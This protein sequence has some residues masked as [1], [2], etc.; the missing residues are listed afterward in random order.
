MCL[1]YIWWQEGRGQGGIHHRHLQEL[2]MNMLKLGDQKGITS[3]VF[4]FQPPVGSGV[5]WHVCWGWGGSWGRGVINTVGVGMYCSCG[6]RKTLLPLSL[7]VC[8]VSRNNM[9]E[10][11]VQKPQLWDQKD[12]AA[13]GL[14]VCAT[15]SYLGLLDHKPFPC[16]LFQ[17]TRRNHHHQQQKHGPSLAHAHRQSNRTVWPKCF[18]RNTCLARCRSSCLGTQVCNAYMH[19]RRMQPA[20]QQ[21][22]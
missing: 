22:H 21:N 15:V 20:L 17:Y 7:V 8:L 5:V 1:S 4:E 16:L 2:L 10:L 12:T 11:L 14:D 9:Q 3:I 18:Q 19:T 6:T 13:F